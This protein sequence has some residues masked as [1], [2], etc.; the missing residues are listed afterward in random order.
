MDAAGCR[1]VSF[2]DRLT[3]MGGV[4][5]EGTRGEVTKE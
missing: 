1:R 2:T 3:D 4:K 5:D